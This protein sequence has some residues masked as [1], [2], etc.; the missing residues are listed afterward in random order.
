MLP[1]VNQTSNSLC[2]IF[3]IVMFAV[4]SRNVASGSK[5]MAKSSQKSS[6]GC[7]YQATVHTERPQ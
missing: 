6:T 1:S 5:P 3:M 7:M 2:S 4:A